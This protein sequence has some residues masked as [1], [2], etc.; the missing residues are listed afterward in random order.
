MFQ[1]TMCPSSGIPPCIPDSH[2]YRI[3]STT[4]R[5]N[6]VVSPDDGHIVARNMWRKEINILRK[7]VH[8]FGF[9]Y[10]IDKTKGEYIWMGHKISI[11][12]K[13]YTY[14]YTLELLVLSEL[15]VLQNISH[16][17]MLTSINNFLFINI[18]QLDALNFIIT[19][20]QAS[21]FLFRAHVL[22][23]CRGLE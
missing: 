10:K 2:P 15:K 5:I 19:L 6:T 13:F 22:E 17:A 3:T 20:F 23:T 11:V 8:Q 4:C 18:H 7:I 12:S 1:A 9:I 16:Y 14:M 21:S